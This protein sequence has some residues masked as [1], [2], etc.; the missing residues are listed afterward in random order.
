[1]VKDKGRVLLFGAFDALTV[2]IGQEEASQPGQ[3]PTLGLS[4]WGDGRPLVGMSG[5]GLRLRLRL[6]LMFM[7][8][9]G[10]WLGGSFV[11]RGF[12][13]T[14]VLGWALEGLC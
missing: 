13:L 1:M 7:F 8:M 9:L 6:M 12:R 3:S 2:F 5:W 14:Y 4:F 11:Q 10:G